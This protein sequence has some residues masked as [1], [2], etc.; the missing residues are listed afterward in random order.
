MDFVELCCNVVQCVEV[1]CNALLLTMATYFKVFKP[2]VQDI[3]Y[4]K[5][6]A[7]HCNTLHHTATHCNTLQH[8]ATQRNIL[9][10]TEPHNNT[11]QR[12]LAQWFKTSRYSKCSATQYSRLQHTATHRNTPQ[13]NTTHC[14]ILQHA[15]TQ[16]F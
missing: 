9:H 8:T 11:L 15:A 10:H 2:L 3:M 16:C 4:S 13:H 1:Y 7:T 5:D 6:P 14:N 12:T